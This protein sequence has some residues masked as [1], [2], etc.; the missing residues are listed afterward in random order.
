MVLYIYK[1][2]IKHFDDA[3]II[4]KWQTV[5]ECR[6]TVSS[7]SQRRMEGGCGCQRKFASRA[8]VNQNTVQKQVPE[9]AQM[10]KDGRR[11]ALHQDF[12]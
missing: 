5:V 11:A 9:G 10:Q 2:Y 6:L 1:M 12:L 7:P 3:K 8:I 4:Y